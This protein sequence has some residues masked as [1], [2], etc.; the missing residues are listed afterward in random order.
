MSFTAIVSA[1]SGTP[2]GTVHLLQWMANRKRQIAASTIDGA[3]SGLH[4]STVIEGSAKITASYNPSPNFLATPARRSPSESSTA[5]KSS[6]HRRP[7]PS[8]APSSLALTFNQPLSGV[9]AQDT[10]NYELLGPGNRRITVTGAVSVYGP[11]G[12][13]VVLSLAQRLVPNVTYTLIVNGVGTV[14]IA[15]TTDGFP[16]DG[17]KNRASGERHVIAIRP[18]SEFVLRRA[19]PRASRNQSPNDAVPR[20]TR[21]ERGP[22]GFFMD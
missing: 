1:T 16:L 21:W 20:K 4:H 10:L 17:E 2:T 7:R 3:R 9:T 14:A 22:G 12:D 6:T 15:N 18:R 13:T 11:V 5:R 8:G 19:E